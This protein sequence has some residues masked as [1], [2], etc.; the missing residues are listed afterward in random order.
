M[1]EWAEQYGKI[2]S[3]T[4]GPTN[5]I[6]LCDRKAVR[7]LI[8]KKSAI[9]SD[10]PADYIGKVLTG[11]DH[12]LIDDYDAVWREKRK[13]MA[14]QLSPRR[15]DEQHSVIQEAEAKCLLLGF[16][17]DPG[18]FTE[19]IKRT[20]ASIASI[21]TYGQ[22]APTID[23]PYATQVFDI[24]QEWTEAMGPGANPPVDVFPILKLWPTRFAPWKQRAYRVN[25]K[26][27]ETWSRT[28]NAVRKRRAA[29]EK[30]DCMA[31]S[32]L[33]EV[34]KNPNYVLGE[35]AIQNL[36]G[37]MIEGGADTTTAQLLTFIVAMATYPRVQAKAQ[38][39][40]DAHIGSDRSPTWKDFDI[41]PY[42]N[43]I[44]KEGLRWRPVTSVGFAHKV[45]EDDT[46]EGMLI[47]KGS[48]VFVAVWTLNHDS[49]HFE[50]EEE[51][52]PERY[53]AFSELANS[54]AGS[55]DYEGRDHYTY[56]AGRR[57]CPG[58][59]LA[60]RNQW[61][62]IAKILWG[63]KISKAID[64]L[65]GEEIPIDVNAYKSGLAQSPL[66]FKVRI[67]PRSEAHAA[68]IRREWA[69]AKEILARYE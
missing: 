25:K 14:Q 62:S 13:Q 44:V 3:L 61:R 42:V 49:S 19:H 48:T 59:H 18:H 56:G 9:Y 32:I 39:L 8:D 31:D 22:R 24:M 17:E 57:I 54:Y 66:P 27:D 58:I 23:H 38:T 41:L 15:C 16:L 65:T 30:R 69:E 64:P 46:Y 34:E 28:L 63:F 47:P 10:R 40:I 55:G 45:R 21:I 43:A 29:G 26:M 12:T 7:D 68:T 5:I 11:G 50:S 4:V 51:Y 1:S 20:T 6:V 52:W 37:E 60:E 53:E 33:D 36:L 35:H 2:Y 67:E